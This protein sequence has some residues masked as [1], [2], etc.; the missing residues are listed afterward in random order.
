MWKLKVMIQFLLSKVPKGEEINYRLQRIKDSY[1]EK[2]IKERI[3]PL[4]NS[5]REITNHLPL[6]GATAVEIGTGWVP[7][8]SVLLYLM[9]VKSCH[10]YDHVAHV[11]HDLAEMLVRCIDDKLDDISRMTSIPASL[12]AV[13]IAKLKNSS[14]IIDFFSKAN[15]VYHAPGDASRTSLADSSVDL[16]YSHAVLEHVPPKVIYALTNESKR[17]L[18]TSGMAY[19]LIG[20]HDH[21]SNFDKKVSKVNFLK[22][23]EF[24]WSFFVKNRI[25]YHNRL[26]EKQHLRIFEECGAKVVW[27]ENKTDPND[28][29]VLR[30]MRIDKSFHGMSPEELAIYESKFLISFG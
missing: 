18:K 24:W 29:V 15:I 19:H 30:N 27:L 7:I 12:L 16:V 2:S 1:N 10:T 20:L 11:R 26:R 25:S 4:V 22:Y 6:D 21:Y 28:I 8:C 13:R 17:I 9:G 5:L 23:S 3:V 14:N